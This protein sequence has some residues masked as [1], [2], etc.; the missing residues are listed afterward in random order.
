MKRR[1]LAYACTAIL[2]G[3]VPFAAL[4]LAG[5]PVLAVAYFAV[6][7]LALVFVGPGFLT[8]SKG[9]Q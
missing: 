5:L 9:D 8:R 4:L 1:A 6:V 3:V 2:L 7:V